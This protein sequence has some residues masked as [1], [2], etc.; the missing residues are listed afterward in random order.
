[1]SEVTKA[2]TI[3]GVVVSNGADKTITVSVTMRVKHPLGKYVTKTRKYLAHDEANQAELGARVVIK[4]VRP[5]SKRKS[6]SLERVVE[7]PK[8]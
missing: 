1:M 5:I 8:S 4:E 6:W 3:E 2:R 7:A